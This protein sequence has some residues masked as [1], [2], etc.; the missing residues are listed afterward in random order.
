MLLY[1]ALHAHNRCK[2]L[3][4]TILHYI[5][6]ADLSA[7][8]LPLATPKVEPAR[9]TKQ[10]EAESSLSTCKE[11]TADSNDWSDNSKQDSKDQPWGRSHL[12]TVK[13][14][15]QTFD[16]GR[17]GAP[18]RSAAQGAAA[19]FAGHLLD[20]VQEGEELD[21]SVYN[22]ELGDED[23]KQLD[24]DVNFS[25]LE[26][27]HL[28]E[29]RESGDEDFDFDEPMLGLPAREM[30][31]RGPEDGSHRPLG[32]GEKTLQAEL[33]EAESR[34]GEGQESEE[35]GAGTNAPLVSSNGK[36]E[37]AVQFILPLKWLHVCASVSVKLLH[38]LKRK[39]CRICCDHWAIQ[40]S[41]VKTLVLVV[42]SGICFV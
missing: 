39:L 27:D 8:V 14:R 41:V 24:A 1:C 28:E 7:S 11:K 6:C 22:V 32:V 18:L 19:L 20:D 16:G 15:P 13:K 26:E 40:P 37:N 4:N 38:H 29:D 42:V 10:R 34:V 3:T 30:E 25:D 12:E 31:E 2:H 33:A 36:R 21:Q 5:Y 23:L 35:E 17:E 9:E